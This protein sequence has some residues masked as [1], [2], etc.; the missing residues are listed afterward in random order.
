[1]RI[2]IVGAGLAGL[3]CA[4]ECER[5]GV[6]PHVYER[7]YSVGWKWPSV[8]GLPDI[9]TNN[10]DDPLKDLREKYNISVKALADIQKN[11]DEVP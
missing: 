2:A 4:I 8:M 1:M 11:C 10:V 7:D 9:F 3:G 6:I 5:L